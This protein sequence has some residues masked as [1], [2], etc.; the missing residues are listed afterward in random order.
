MRKRKQ[1]VKAFMM[2]TGAQWRRFLLSPRFGRHQCSQPSWGHQACSAS[3]DNPEWLSGWHLQPA[4]L[5]KVMSSGAHLTSRLVD[6]LEQWSL[7]GGKHSSL[8]IS[9]FLIFSASSNERPLTLSVIYELDAMA[10]PHPK[11]LNLTSEMMPCS[12]TRIW[13]FMTSPQLS[14]YR[15]SSPTVVQN[16]VNDLRRGT[17]QPSTDIS[18]ILWERAHLDEEEKLSD[19]EWKPGPLKTYVS[20]LFVV[21]DHFFMVTA[22]EYGSGSSSGDA[23][24]GVDERF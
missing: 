24:G 12:S 23:R 3:T 14:G 2:R 21:R 19:N 8:A 11:V 7:T 1:I 4:L 13:S 9:V 16:V 10:E 20:R 6:L 17:D 15:Q 5:V 18:V 22:S